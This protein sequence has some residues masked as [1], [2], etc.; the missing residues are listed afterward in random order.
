M[1]FPPDTDFAI[2]LAYH[3]IDLCEQMEAA[4]RLEEAQRVRQR[5]GES[6]RRAW[7]DDW[8]DARLCNN[9]AWALVSQGP[10]A[11]E[12]AA[13][14]RACRQ[15]CAARTQAWRFLEHARSGAIPRRDVE[16]RCRGIRRVD[17]AS[18]R[19]RPERLAVHGNG[20]PSAERARRG[21]GLVRSVARVDQGS[22]RLPISI[23]L[24]SR[25]GGS[26]S[27]PGRERATKNDRN[28]ISLSLHLIRF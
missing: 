19:R 14:R 5:I 11:D 21:K 13:R 4:G 26:C 27:R 24:D 6:A 16:R 2:S 22:R 17:A 10:P 23:R 12:A 7:R 18:R 9:L 15:G 20:P 25:R 3:Q 28:V 1:T 8:S